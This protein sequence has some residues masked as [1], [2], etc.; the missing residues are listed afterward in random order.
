MIALY[1]F[2]FHCE[3]IT[4]EAVIEQQE[5]H[6]LFKMLHKFQWFA[7]GRPH[8]NRSNSRNTKPVK[9]KLIVVVVVVV[10]VVLVVVVLVVVGVVLIVVVVVSA[11]PV[12]VGR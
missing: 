8:G 12:V 1:T 9:Q 4:P 10:F 11:A 5:G 3:A 7:F 2:L 6:L